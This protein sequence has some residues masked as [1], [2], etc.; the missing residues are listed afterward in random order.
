MNILGLVFSLLLILSYGF[1][2]CWDKQV[3]SSRLRSTYLG[4]NQV[5][6]KI[7]KTY[8]SE[9]Y[10]HLS[11]ITK[12][13]DGEETFRTPPE[14]IPREKKIELNRECAKINLWPL[15]QEGKE[16]H[17]DL[18]HFALKLIHTFYPKSAGPLL[19]AILSAASKENVLSL[20]KLKLKD[21]VL[22]KLYYKMLKGTKV[23]NLPKKNGYPSLLDYFKIENSSDKLCLFHAHPDL[24]SLLLGTE[25]AYSL[26]EEIHKKE[27]PI[28]TKEL[29]EKAALESSHIILDPTLLDLFEFGR[30]HHTENKKTLIA[31]DSKTHVQLRKSLNM[32]G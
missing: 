19:D 29:I 24:I 12:P 20:E 10:K 17:S 16:K 3:A 25:A 6:R 22:Q 4:H 31:E 23:C 7:L 8:Q 1:Y 15:I 9:I 30:P 5:N 14:K 13:S 28:L 32:K 26:H 11:S 27:G 21:P 2:A 18:Y